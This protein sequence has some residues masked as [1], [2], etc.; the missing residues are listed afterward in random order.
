MKDGTH[1][2]Q[3]IIG[4]G[5]IDWHCWFEFVA[6]GDDIVEE[7]SYCEI[8]PVDEGKNGG[9]KGD[10]I[11]LD[12]SEL[13]DATQEQIEQAAYRALNEYNREAAEHQHSGYES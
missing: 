2:G 9:W 6:D 13:P 5:G 1:A 11:I 4:F 8:T 3:T 12:H 10:R 7:I